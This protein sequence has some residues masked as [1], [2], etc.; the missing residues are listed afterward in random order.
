MAAPPPA[1]DPAAGRAD[2]AGRSSPAPASKT[3]PNT[4]L[5]NSVARQS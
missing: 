5:S 3:A 4:G 2:Q 1:L